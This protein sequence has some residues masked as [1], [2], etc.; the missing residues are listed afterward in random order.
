LRR[1]HQSPLFPY[2][3]LFRSRS[4]AREDSQGCRVRTAGGSGRDAAVSDR[5][6][7]VRRAAV[8]MSLVVTGLFVFVVSCAAGL[9]VTPRVRSVGLR[10]GLV[11]ARTADRWHP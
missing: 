9:F 1:P 2:T 7:A 8:G 11:A 3:T 5:I 10:M 4:L 6:R